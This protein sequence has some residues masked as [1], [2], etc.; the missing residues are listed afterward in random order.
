[1]FLLFGLGWGHTVAQ[2]T[3]ASETLASASESE[4]GQVDSDCVHGDAHR[5]P[6][7]AFTGWQ[8]TVLF[9]AE[10][11]TGFLTAWNDVLQEG[12]SSGQAPLQIAYF[13]GSHVQA[14]RIGWSFRRRLTSDFPGM[15]VGRGI[16]APQRLVH[17]NGPPERG[18][19]AEGDWIRA[20]CA[21]RRHEG[22]WGIT[23]MEARCTAPGDGLSFWTGEPA[24]AECTAALRLLSRPE[25][26]ALWQWTEQGLDAL[27]DTSLGMQGIQT[28]YMLEGQ[29]S[30][31]T[32]RLGH[33]HDQPAV[34]QGVE[35]I[36][37]AADCIFHDLGANGAHSA[38][39]LRNPHFPGQLEALAPDLAILAFGINDAH[40]AQGRFDPDRFL[41]H[42]RDLL[43]TVRA[44]SPGTEVLLVTNN[45]SHYRGRHNA[46]A[47]QVRR[48]MREL[49]TTEDVACWDL[50]RQLGG[51]GSIDRLHAA[52][53]AADDRL[54][55]RRDGYILIGEMLYELLARAAAAIA[56]QAP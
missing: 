34:L 7:L 4:W 41:R 44:A 47:E 43:D 49:V 2:E 54:H 55:F 17:S 35:W 5:D 8:D 39:W 18:W 10:S 46:H 15:V 13:G 40:M 3:A 31:D 20:S 36:P 38:S 48:A 56:K 11:L 33:P 16:Q 12:R 32:L 45:D 42:Y 26:S 19:H 21:H 29:A 51:R 25:S 50:Y 27:K 52:G 53:F 22:K 28:W 1:M 24:G 14:G 30:P 9:G 23:G 37:A 6:A